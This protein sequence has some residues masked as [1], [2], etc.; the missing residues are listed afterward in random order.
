M[1]HEESGRHLYTSFCPDWSNPVSWVTLGFAVSSQQCW[2]RKWKT[3][4]KLFALPP[5]VLGDVFPIRKSLAKRGGGYPPINGRDRGFG[6]LSLKCFPFEI[7]AALESLLSGVRMTYF[8][9][10]WQASGSLQE[11]GGPTICWTSHQFTSVLSHGRTSSF[12]KL[13]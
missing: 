10:T 8:G 3:A 13:V 2:K 1:I 9:E 12:V 11:G 5:P 6:P 4:T 7:W